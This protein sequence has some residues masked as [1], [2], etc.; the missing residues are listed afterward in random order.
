MT[1]LRA[2]KTTISPFLLN[3][4]YFK[5]LVLFFILR[6]TVNRIDVNLAA[7]GTEHDL[8]LALLITF[9]VSIILTSINSFFLRK[10]FFK[11][12][13]WLNFVFG[14]ASPLL[15]AVYHI[16]LT[17]MKHRT[18]N[19]KGKVNKEEL[20]RK[21]KRNETLIN[22]LQQTRE[23]EIGIEAV[24]Q[25]L[26]LLGL[27]CFYPYVFKAPSGRTYSYFFGV[28][29]LVLKGNH[30]LFFA[31]L[32]CSF[33]GPCLFY[34]NRN[35]VLCHGSLN[36]TRKLILMTQ[37]MFFLF[38][39]VLSITSAIFMPVISQWDVFV[40]NHGLDASSLLD[41]E[42]LR[43][44]FQTYFGRGLSE[45]TADVRK[46]SLFFLAFVFIHLMLITNY[47]L[48]YS[49]KITKSM[50][51]EWMVHLVSSFWLPLPFLTIEGVKKGEEKAELWFLVALHSI[52]NFVII[53]ASRLTYLQESYPFG[54]VIFDCVLALFNI[55]GVL[56]SIFYVKKVELYA[57]L[58]NELPNLPSFGPEVS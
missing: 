35:Q 18:A 31:S 36:V 44:E 51:K 8:I 42:T 46:N 43:F 28:A 55:L 9:C 37:Y 39:R 34:T 15:P 5:D 50:M 23:L 10:R 32:L 53:L 52:E 16:Q 7:S 58:P 40:A 49:P 3:L 56:L 2:M 17:Q 57:G 41:A 20:K 4:D 54:I 38:V 13:F 27:I 21:E 25:I 24:M 1:F 11:T 29:F 12:N 19:Q 33:L 22:S 45:V 48:F 47:S 26:L 6:E 14:F 30:V